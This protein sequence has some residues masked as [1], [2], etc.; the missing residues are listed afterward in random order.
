MSDA[1]TK[2]QKTPAAAPA[3]TQAPDDLRKE[4]KALVSDF[5]RAI[6][7]AAKGGDDDDGD[8][9]A[10]TVDAGDAGDGEPAGRFPETLTEL[11]D[12]QGWD[13]DQVDALKLNVKVNGEIRQVTMKDVVASYQTLEAAE[14]K[15]AKSKSFAQEQAQK[16]KERSQVLDQSYAVAAGMI[17]ATEKDLLDDIGNADLAK[18]RQ[19][20][21]A[22]YSAA[23]LD[24]QRRR[25]R[26]ENMKAE[27]A[28]GWTKGQQDLREKATK[29]KAARVGEEVA[30]LVKVFPEWGDKTKAKAGMAKL[31]DY[32][33]GQGFSREDVQ[34]ASDHRLFAAFEK[35]RRWDE[36]QAHTKAA[37]KKVETAP[38]VIRPGPKGKDKSGPVDLNKLTVAQYREYRKK[39]GAPFR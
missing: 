1:P 10:D 38:T 16:L 7:A 36:Q 21:P 27:L 4:P 12:A 14:D 18:L 26:I 19:E 29:E 28:E 9:G 15:L 37:V 11:I 33:V 13:P 8:A 25:D 20:D 22:E 39:Q 2:E 23:L 5:R 31:T 30:A 3:A 17:E 24:F 35:A 6:E 32:L 34:D